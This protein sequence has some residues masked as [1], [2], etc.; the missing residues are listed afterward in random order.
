MSGFKDFMKGIFGGGGSSQKKHPLYSSKEYGPA[1][2]QL[3]Q[4]Y[5]GDE[6]KAEDEFAALMQTPFGQYKLR[7]MAM[8]ITYEKNPDPKAFNADKLGGAQMFGDTPG[9]KPV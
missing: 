8:E 2:T 7:R 3:V 9:S 6:K 5:E 1:F 4:K